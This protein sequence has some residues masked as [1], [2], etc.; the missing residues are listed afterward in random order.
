M[1]GNGAYAQ[2]SSHVMAFTLRMAMHPSME[3]S[4]L[5]GK[6]VA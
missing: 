5:N 2:I 1:V 3:R 6:G 4:G